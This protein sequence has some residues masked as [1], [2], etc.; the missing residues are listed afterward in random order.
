MRYPHAWLQVRMAGRVGASVVRAG[1]EGSR[2]IARNVEDYEALACGMARAPRGVAW[3][4]AVRQAL[5]R[6]RQGADGGSVLF[7]VG[8]WVAAF[9]SALRLLWELHHAAG[10]TRMAGSDRY[11][12]GHLVVL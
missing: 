12:T 4:R 8:R 5:R 10:A 1:G 7:D 6:R 11:A 9:D 2:L 3:V